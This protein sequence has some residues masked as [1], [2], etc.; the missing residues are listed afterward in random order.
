MKKYFSLTTILILSIFSTGKAQVYDKKTMHAGES[1]SEV[2]YYL[3]PSFKVATVKFKNGGELV[4]QLNFNM[5]ICQIQFIDPK[6]DTLNLAKLEDIDEIDFDSTSFFYNQGY[7]QVVS[8]SDIADLAILRKVSY[9]PVKIGALGLRNHSGTGT[10]GYGSFLDNSTEKK[11]TLNE[12]VDITRQTTFFLLTAN[13]E[14]TKANR[15]GFLKIFSKNNQLIKTYIK[16]SKPD[17]NKENDL[18]I[19]FNFCTNGH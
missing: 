7:Y 2:S 17:F 13:G 14:K 8:K 18:K 3:F 15:S 10:E 5:L 6:G 19:L 16:E 11:L 1:L 4:S 9:E 12:D